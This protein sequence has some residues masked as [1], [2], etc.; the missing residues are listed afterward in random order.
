MINF[1]VLKRI[2]IS[3][4]ALYP[5]ETENPG[6]HIEFN[7]GLTLIVGANGLGKT[8]LITILYRLLSGPYDI[9]GLA[10]QADLGGLRLDAKEVPYSDRVAFAQRVAD[11]AKDARARLVLSFGSQDVVIERRLSNLALTYFQIEDNVMEPSEANF[12]TTIAGLAGVWSFGDWILLLRHL[13]FYF[14]GRRA[15]VWDP[16][17]QRQILRFLFLSV[18]RA[19]KWTEDERAVL[20][21][22]S[23]MRNLSAA[24]TREEKALTANEFKTKAGVSVRQRLGTLEKEQE[25]DQASEETLNEEIMNLEQQRQ[26]ARLALM[27]AEQE[28]E[29]RLREHERAKLLSI[30]SRFP[31]ESETARYLLAQLLT[32]DTCLACGHTAKKAA[33]DYKS[34]IEEERCVICNSDLSVDSDIIPGATIADKQVEIASQSLATINVQLDSSKEMLMSAEAA[35]RKRIM[36][37]QSTTARIAERSYE[38]DT[39]VKRLP[40]EEARMHEQRKELGALRSRVQTFRDELDEK[41]KLFRE[42]VEELNLQVATQSEAVKSVFDR[43]AEG[44]LVEVC[45]LI[46]STK[47]ARLGQTGEP[48]DFPA[49]ELE[50]TGTNFQTPVRRSGPEEVSESQREFIDL[51]FRMALIKV[52]GA[53]GTGTLIIDAPESS[54]D[55][56]FVSRA[57]NVLTRFAQDQSNRLVVTSNL[58]EGQLI[59]SLI[60]KAIPSGERGSRIVDLLKLAEPTAAVKQLHQEYAEV[61]DRILGVSSGS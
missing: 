32:E 46:W 36:E 38:M 31:T 48:F 27:K 12:H 57:T 34:R 58:V 52:A 39:L 25:A 49:F 60:E 6:L 42:F 3:N 7:S 16:T 33:D 26:N 54:L 18:D 19:R 40:P 22:D 13:V 51:S 50:M 5:G 4:Y 43:Y 15:L 35:H 24:L 53:N 20:E 11:G 1:P 47:K 55:A 21:L 9:P 8:T 37:L 10:T 2:D 14:E 29:S 59:P 61:R 28:R 17:A 45:N 30:A 41:R 56:V 23:R 44:F